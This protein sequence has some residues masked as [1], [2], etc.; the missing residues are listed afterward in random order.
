MTAGDLLFEGLQL[1]MREASLFAAVGFL[2]LGVS[3]VAVDAAWLIFAARR[4]LARRGAVLTAAQ[5]PPAAQPGAM[6]VFVPAWDE[7]V[8]IGDMLRHTITA[9]GDADYRLYVGCY[10]NDPATVAAVRAVADPRIR[11]VVGP[12]AGPTSKADN[13]NR[14][15]DRMI[16][17]EVADGRRFKAVLLHDAEDIVHSAELPLFDSLIERYDLVQ[18]P[19]VPLIDRRSRWIGGH[20]LD[21]FAES[22]GKEMVVRAALDAGLP[23]AGV[24]CAFS[25]NALEE[26][27]TARGAPF[28][29]DSLTEDY[30]LGLR[31]R[32]AGRSATFVRLPAA[33][34][35]ALVAT[36]G[37]F[38]ASLDAAV[39]QKARW[40]TGIA[41]IGWDRLGWNGG[42]AERWMRL[43]DRQ[44]VMG[45]VLVAAGYL[46]ILCWGALLVVAT[47][48]GR[49]PHPSSDIFLLLVTMATILLAWRLA[50]RC[51]FVA[52]SHGFR[53]A[54]RSPFRT[55]VGNAV[56]ILAASRALGRYQA[57][58][59]TGRA[60][61][62]KTAHAFPEQVPAE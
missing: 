54:L 17:D 19:V 24:G 38:P 52:R 37:Y 46:A 43:R 6:A 30:E 25:R 36:K 42:F 18:L 51:F 53:E 10:P 20:Y 27:A 15:W 35:R 14:I 1:V 12:G 58:R 50:V 34:G 29:T 47:L 48:T 55:L 11:L 31:F 59:R 16:E 33:E 22:H 7:A 45:A 44:S 3:D 57:H 39:T 40:M 9:F 56:A 2:I 5:V 13:L 23:A 21:E 61:W 4:R 49:Q 62:D 41:L 26:T 28:D 8:V 60:V 32:D